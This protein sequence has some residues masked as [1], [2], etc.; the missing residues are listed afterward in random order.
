[1][2]LLITIIT[3]TRIITTIIITAKARTVRTGIALL[4]ELSKRV[5]VKTR[6]GRKVIRKYKVQ[7]DNDIPTAEERIAN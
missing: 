4:E 7:S 2:I 3:I 1:M 5:T 6:K